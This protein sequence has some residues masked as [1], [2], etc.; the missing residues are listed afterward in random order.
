Q[1]AS[2][3]EFSMDL[4]RHAARCN[5]NWQ[6]QRLQRLCYAGDRDKRLETI[7]DH[8]ANTLEIR[9]RQGAAP[10][11]LDNPQ[12]FCVAHAAEPLDEVVF[13]D[14]IAAGGQHRS[15]GSVD[16]WLAVDQNPIAVENY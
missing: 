10:L 2:E 14:R 13:R 4:L 7:L 12:H 15:V 3:L 9:R 1:Q 6:A 8:R 11:V 16:D 5:A